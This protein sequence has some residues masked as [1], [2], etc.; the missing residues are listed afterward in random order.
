MICKSHQH[1]KIVL[2]VISNIVPLVYCQVYYLN[3][4]FNIFLEKVHSNLRFPIIKS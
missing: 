3:V 4:Q 1:N 2:L